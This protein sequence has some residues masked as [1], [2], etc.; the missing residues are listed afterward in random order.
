[1]TPVSTFL[2]NR[3]ISSVT[4]DKNLSNQIKCHLPEDIIKKELQQKLIQ[5]LCEL[6]FQEKSVDIQ[7]IN[8]DSMGI[9]SRMELEIFVFSRQEL[10]ECIQKITSDTIYEEYFLRNR[11]F[12][13][14][15]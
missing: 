5:R 13:D 6:I 2:K 14:N 9:I 7:N 4:L 3:F 10:I 15:W 11:P 1:M 12:G 8:V